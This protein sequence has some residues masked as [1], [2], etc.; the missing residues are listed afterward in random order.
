VDNLTDNIFRVI[1]I[2]AFTV[3][4]VVVA[5]H[6]IFHRSK[7]IKEPMDRPKFKWTSIYA[8][9]KLIC[10]VTFICT[11]SLVITGFFPLLV[12]GRTISGYW[13]IIHVTAAAVFVCCLALLTLMYA[14]QNL[15]TKYALF[16]GTT[17]WLILLLGLPLIL[18]TVLSMFT[19]FGT[20]VQELL[21]E[22]HRYSAL[23]VSIIAIMHIYLTIL[24]R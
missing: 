16:K 21:A 7:S 18:S 15:L 8:F 9:K 20:D 10:F 23:L 12:L 1:S 5:L 11:L 13:L 3:T 2:T 19:F 17:F 14:E 24:Y 6:S 22:I 4:I